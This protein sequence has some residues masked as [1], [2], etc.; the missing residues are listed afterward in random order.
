MGAAAV[1]SASHG[2]K[3]PPACATFACALQPLPLQAQLLAHS[4]APACPAAHQLGAG[5]GAGPGSGPLTTASACASSAVGQHSQ[6]ISRA[7]G[8]L[9]KLL[10]EQPDRVL[11]SLGCG[12]GVSCCE[13]RPRARA[14]PA[15][16]DT[17]PGSEEHAAALAAMHSAVQ[18]RLG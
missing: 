6:L 3:A 11:A 9:E 17:A 15:V 8:A 16:A 7:L 13:P 18:A 12:V 5:A 4:A 10:F 14:A 2:A 1:C